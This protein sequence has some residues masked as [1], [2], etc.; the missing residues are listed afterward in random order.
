MEWEEIVA[1]SRAITPGGK[2]LGLSSTKRLLATLQGRGDL[3]LWE[4]RPASNAEE[5][6]SFVARSTLQ[7]RPNLL[8]LRPV[9][10]LESTPEE[11][12]T[13]V[14]FLDSAF[15]RFVAVG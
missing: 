12:M 6:S 2:L 15:P 13:S 10:K 14:V 4:I 7:A 3:H 8:T 5:T 11:R 9:A 1:L